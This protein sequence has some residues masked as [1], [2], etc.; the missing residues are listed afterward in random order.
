MKWRRMIIHAR[1]NAKQKESRAWFRST[2][3]W[4]MLPTR[5][6]WA[7][8]LFRFGFIRLVG[9]STNEKDHSSYSL[10]RSERNSTDCFSG[11]ITTTVVFFSH[12]INFEKQFTFDNYGKQVLKTL[13]LKHLSQKKSPEK[14][15][16]AVTAGQKTVFCIRQSNEEHD[17]PGG[18][19]GSASW[20]A[21]V[22]RPSLC[23]LSVL[24]ARWCLLVDILAT[25]CLV[26]FRTTDFQVG[27]C[28]SP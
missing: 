8:L 12:T 16:L 3:L 11:S 4:V 15:F 24:L 10:P 23:A 25:L 26:H 28:S 21:L 13:L 7:T 17:P 18:A 1:K 19:G 22:C 2:D 6:L 14:N 5:F 9:Q 27:R 20:S